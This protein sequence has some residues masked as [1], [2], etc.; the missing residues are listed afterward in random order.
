MQIVTQLVKKFSA[1]YG[2]RRFITVFTTACH[3]SPSWARCI[4]STISLPIYLRTILI[5][6][7]HLRLDHPSGLFP[8]GIPTKILYTFLISPM[9]AKWPSHPIVLYL[10][11]L[12]I[13]GE[14]Y[15]LWSSLCSL[16]HSPATSSPEW[17]LLMFSLATSWLITKWHRVHVHLRQTM[18]RKRNFMRCYLHVGGSYGGGREAQ[19]T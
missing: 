4:Q 16:L 19:S 12:I 2:T 13:C 9:C 17:Y 5:L 14:A 8:S 15:K 11:T 1:L 6:S 7:S 18:N 10:I 3:C